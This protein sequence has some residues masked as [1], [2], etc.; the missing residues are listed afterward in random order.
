MEVVALELG[1]ADGASEELRWEQG[2]DSEILDRAWNRG[3]GD[4]VTA[5]GVSPSSSPTFLIQVGGRGG[6]LRGRPEG[7]TAV[8]VD[9]SARATAGGRRNGHEAPEKAR[10]AMTYRVDA[11]VHAVQSSARD[12]FGDRSSPT[13]SQNRQLL[14]RHDSMLRSG[15]SS[16]LGI[17]R[18]AFVRHIRT[19]ATGPWTLP[20]TPLF[21]AF[22]GALEGLGGLGDLARLQAPRADVGAKGAAVLLD[23]DLLQIRVEA[24]LGGDHGVASGLAERGSLAAAVTDLRHRSRDGT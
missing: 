1:L 8:E 14:R 24:A 10:S 20:L 7:G 21:F 15:D 5:G 23:P 4:V 17:E 18:V 3:D 6:G 2:G 13:E 9:A 16:E 22:F 12:P 19:K 11:L